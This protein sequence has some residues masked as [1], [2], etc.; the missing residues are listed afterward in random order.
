MS[1]PNGVRLSDSIASKII[2]G[3]LPSDLD[4]LRFNAALNIWEFVPFGGGAGG[5]WSAIET[6]EASIAEASHVFSFPAIDFDDDSL[7]VLT[8]D[9][10][11]TASTNLQIRINGIATSYNIDGSRIGLGV[12]TLID[13]NGAVAGQLAS[14]NLFGGAANTVGV[15]CWISI[16]KAGT[17]DRPT[18]RSVAAIAG[19]MEH[20]SSAN[21]AAVASVTSIEVRTSSSSWRIGSRATLYRV[22]RT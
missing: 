14:S 8:F 15:V 19:I 17:D 12:E 10:A 18:M 4:G 21:L 9:G 16:G 20:Q 5:V 6:Y 1:F 2:E 7:L 22:S 11:A 13:L 3:G